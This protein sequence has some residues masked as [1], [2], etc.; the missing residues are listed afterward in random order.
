[1]ALRERERGGGPTTE[2]ISGVERDQAVWP[3]NSVLACTIHIYY[4][5]DSILGTAS[6]KAVLHV[7]AISTHL[8]D[9]SPRIHSVRVS[10]KHSFSSVPVDVWVCRSLTMQGLYL[11]LPLFGRI[12]HQSAITS[13]RPCQVH[14]QLRA[15]SSTPAKYPRNG[16]ETGRLARRARRLGYKGTFAVTWSPDW[17]T[18]L[19]VA[20]R[21]HR[22]GSSSPYWVV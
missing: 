8:S 6:D 3:C 2:A 13:Q 10:I 16:H 22:G 20:L 5:T 7:R 21:C 12:I 17:L 11:A 14:L 4:T 9:I 18:H 1:V 15:S 19:E